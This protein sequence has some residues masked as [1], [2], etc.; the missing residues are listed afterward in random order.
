MATGPAKRAAA[1]AL[2]KATNATKATTSKQQPLRPAPTS[3]T[4]ATAKPTG[5]GVKASSPPLSQTPPATMAPSSSSSTPSAP[6]Q[7]AND[8]TKEASSEGTPPPTRPPPGRPKGKQQEEGGPKEQQPFNKWKAAIWTLAF[9]A[10]TVTGTIYGAGLK[11]Q[12]EW[13]EEKQKVQEATVEEKIETL[14][15]RRA[16]LFKTKVEI[17]QKLADVRERIR[18]ERE[19]EEKERSGAVAMPRR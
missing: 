5:G 8:L 12:K 2:K 19:K 15:N 1:S 16:Q 9:T 18:L 17:E 3:P 13:E 7:P 14:V 10:V 6:S 11:T 4:A